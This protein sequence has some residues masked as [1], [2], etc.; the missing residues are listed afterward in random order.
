MASPVT[1]RYRILIDVD[2]VLNVLSR[3]EPFFASSAAVLAAC[4]TGLEGLVAAHTV[5]TLF[6]LLSKYH[7]ARY[8][9][10]QIA[11]L[12]SIVQVAAV[13][14]VVIRQALAAQAEDFRVHGSFGRCDRDVRRSGLRGLRGVRRR[15]GGRRNGRR[16]FR[17]R[18]RRF[19]RGGVEC[20][21]VLG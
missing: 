18:R 2:V 17:G 13:D 10:T 4:E 12:L 15:G 16:C 7:D 5:T 21:G 11:D 9:R 8:A 6:Y 1:L 19:R 14:S 20:I 3:R